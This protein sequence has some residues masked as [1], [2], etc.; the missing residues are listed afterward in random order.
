MSGFMR[1]YEAQLIRRDAKEMILSD[2]EAADVEVHY[3][4]LSGGSYD[5]VYQVQTG[6]TLV[7]GIF[8]SPSLKAIQKIVQPKDQQIWK[9]GIMEVGDCIFYFDTSADIKSTQNIPFVVVPVV[10]D[11]YIS[12]TAVGV[13]N[14][15]ATNLPTGNLVSGGTS[16]L[17]S[18][19]RSNISAIPSNATILSAEF[20][21]TPINGTNIIA[22][23]QFTLHQVTTDF[24]AATSTW[25]SPW[26][27]P[28]GD[29]NA[30]PVQTV[31]TDNAITPLVFNNAGFVALVV[32]AIQNRSG[33]LRT[34]LRLPSVEGSGTSR[35]L[36]FA[37]NNHPTVAIPKLT[38]TYT[39]PVETEIT[40]IN[41][42]GSPTNWIPIPMHKNKGFEDTIAVRVGN[43]VLF[44]PIPCKL[45][46]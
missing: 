31:S 37:S 1:G 21:L 33:I 29:F 23:T 32:D 19:F 3:Q 4:Y 2:R 7:T 44:Q 46:R 34:E 35:Q 6:G 18:L 15:T 30:T 41:I 8:Y 39:V 27:T 17:R 43:N 38:I 22:G 14:S 40:S 28:G 9:W 25:N 20:V 12:S 11:N 10:D 36:N 13:N 42:V 5:S 24:N 16:I 45:K 26:V